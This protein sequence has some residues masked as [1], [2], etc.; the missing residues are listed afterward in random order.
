M[1]RKTAQ[2]FD[3][4]LLL[5]FDQY[6]HGAIDRRGFLDRATKFAVGGVTAGMLLDSLSPKFAEAQQV[7]SVVTHGTRYLRS[8]SGGRN[9][10]P[11]A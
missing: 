10:A 6:V 2:D 3:Q 5:I 8:S 11:T 1:E 4:E 7:P 9:R